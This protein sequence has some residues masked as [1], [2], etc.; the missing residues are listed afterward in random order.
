MS[1]VFFDDAPVI[2]LRQS[3]ERFT[4]E[5]EVMSGVS[6]TWGVVQVIYDTLRILF[7]QVM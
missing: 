6:D 4:C 5:G 7:P 3:M 1:N 2:M